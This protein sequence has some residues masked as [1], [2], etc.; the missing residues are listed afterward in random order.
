MEEITR[1]GRKAKIFAVH[2]N[3][4]VYFKGFAETFQNPVSWAQYKVTIGAFLASLSQRGLASVTV[5]E[6]ESFC[7]AEGSSNA[8]VKSS[9]IHIKCLLKWAA[10]N[11]VNAYDK[12]ADRSILLWLL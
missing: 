12:K 3:N 5:E 9:T 4:Q 11:K 8:K 1:K 10:K 6:I 7:H 2:S